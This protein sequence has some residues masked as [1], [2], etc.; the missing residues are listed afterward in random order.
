MLGTFRNI[1]N[2]FFKA[3]WFVPEQQNDDI[4]HR[5]VKFVVN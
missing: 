1:D 4:I 3:V 2:T 5:N